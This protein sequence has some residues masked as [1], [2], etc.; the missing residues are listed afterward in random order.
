MDLN[1]NDLLM[2]NEFIKEP[3]LTTEV[4]P[5]F[6]EE[7][8][9]YYK[10]ELDKLE[11][12]RIESKL[13]QVSLKSLLLSEDTDP[14]DL[15]NTNNYSNLNGNSNTNVEQKRVQ[16][17]VKTYVSIDSRNRNLK[18][19]PSASY[20]KIFLG[21]TFYN[22]KSVKIVSIEFP[23]SNSV[24]NNSNQYIFWENLEDI[25]NGYINNFTQNYNKYETFVNT[26]NY[27]ANTL[28]AELERQLNSVSRHPSTNTNHEF[29]LKTNVQTN[30]IE[31]LSV[32][33]KQLT[34]QPL[35]IIPG[36]STI[37]VNAVNHGLNTDDYVTIVDA[38]TITVGIPDNIGNGRYQI[39][40]I[41]DNKFS[42]DT[43]LSSIIPGSS[44]YFFGGN[45][46]KLGYD[47]PFQFL[48]GDY[49][50]T[51]S[52]LL[53][54][55]RENSSNKIK[56]Y[57]KT[58]TNFFQYKVTTESPH[59][60]EN[61]FDYVGKNILIIA[62]TEFNINN[63]IINSSFKISKILNTH[64]FLI[65]CTITV[66]N[67]EE[68]FAD[69]ATKHI[70][71]ARLL[72]SNNNV[73]SVHNI[74]EIINYEQFEIKISTHQNSPHNLQFNDINTEITFYESA[75]I[76][77]IDGVK[78]ISSILSSYEFTITGFVLGTS[79]I[80]ETDFK[81]GDHGH[82][83]TPNPIETNL[84]YIQNVSHNLGLTTFQTT[85]PHQLIIGDKIKIYGLVTTPNINSDINEQIFTVVLIQNNTFSIEQEL[86]S[87]DSTSFSNVYITTQIAKITCPFHGFNFII[88]I[89]REKIGIIN[90]AGNLIVP[91]EYKI[92]TQLP[93]N[94]FKQVNSSY[95]PI[96][97]FIYINNTNTTPPID[98][99]YL[100]LGYV[101]QDE[102]IIK[103]IQESNTP[104]AADSDPSGSTG[105]IKI[106]QNFRLYRTENIDNS[107]IDNINNI[108]YDLRNIIDQHT[109]TINL[110]IFIQSSQIGGGRGMH[111][112]SLNH[113]FRAIQSNSE[114]GKL[115]RA[116]SIEGENYVFL[117][118]PQ[119][120]TMLNTGD[121]TDIFARI[122]IERSPGNMNFSFL[123][124]PKDFDVVPLNSLSEFEFSIRN[125]DNTFYNFNNLDYSFVLEITE[126]KDTIDIFNYSSRRGISNSNVMVPS[127]SN[128][129]NNNV[130]SNLNK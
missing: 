18:N 117:C 118:C 111:I 60:F 62:T 92:K 76:P 112:S 64:T 90:N 16:K 6:N 89:N 70:G 40:K 3:E 14:D 119:L 54:F 50:N 61:N 48:F 49:N 57:L 8:R 42:Y 69:L 53:G 67:T 22:V 106:N 1:E 41:N 94:L 17:E 71:I 113:G 99:K 116:V 31:F 104:V 23:N 45:G 29:I 65:D 58:F 19:Y 108:S 33:I 63:I 88:D 82:F 130:T 51:I 74:T 75:V 100:L 115:F 34:D 4:P 123:S 12:K 5:E 32:I 124:N 110:P 72:D 109:F 73:I 96:L 121:V 11:Q 9:T 2:T 78:K 55:P 84:L 120:A 80:S 52:E 83:Y 30:I 107:V 114:D 98:G 103:Q 68:R 125:Y 97:E 86:T 122:T 66:N 10:N 38:R 59:G 127:I 91:A 20:F 126:I 43:K 28:K 56:S 93:H 39:T 13:E 15:Q 25:E 95:E 81:V 21:K 85:T 101:D 44:E 47:A 26:G 46:V 129:S 128:T 79:Y 37:T 35:S 105:I 27:N 87:I 7:F 102:F 24:F 36:D 77:S